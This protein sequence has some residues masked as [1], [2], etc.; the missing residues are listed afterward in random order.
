MESQYLWTVSK[1]IMTSD[2]LCSLYFI[3]IAWNSHLTNKPDADGAFNLPP[4]FSFNVTQQGKERS[5][6]KDLKLHQGMKL[7]TSGTEHANQL[8]TSLPL[9]VILDGDYDDDDNDNAYN[10]EIVMVM[11]DDTLEKGNNNDRFPK[12]PFPFF[13]ALK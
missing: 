3:S 9:K 4:P 1:F 11:M 6:N 7:E 12:I 5:P 8:C 10:D 13:E 2:R